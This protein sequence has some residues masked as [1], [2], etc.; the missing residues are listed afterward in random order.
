MTWESHQDIM[1]VCKQVA[2]PDCANIPETSNGVLTGIFT[3]SR[4]SRPWQ[5]VTHREPE[6]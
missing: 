1:H 2:G 4:C 6:A 5:E 3:S